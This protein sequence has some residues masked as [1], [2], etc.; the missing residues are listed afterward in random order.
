MSTF[1]SAWRDLN[2]PVNC[3]YLHPSP[4]SGL[5]IRRSAD[6]VI[7]PTCRRPSLGNRIARF[8]ETTNLPT[9][10]LAMDIA[11]V[12][13]Q[14]LELQCT[15]PEALIFY[16]VKANPLPEIIRA[17]ADI[18]ASFDVSSA[19]EIEQCLAIGVSPRQLSFGNTI[20]KAA[21]IADAHA[22]AWARSG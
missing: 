12:V 11:D 14:Y 20:K 1:A 2:R 15:L 18:G 8:L 4:T 16:A 7:M 21:V 22:A 17:L 9:P 6:L 13:A 3:P 10:F 19:A 5:A